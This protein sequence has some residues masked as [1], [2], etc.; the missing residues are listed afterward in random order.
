MATYATTQD[1]IDAFGLREMVQL[2]NLDDA[3]AIAI[4]LPRLIQN[5]EKAF[6]R[7]N[8]LIAN[9]PD[10]R[11][12][13]PFVLEPINAANFDPILNDFELDLVRYYL[14][15]VLPR[16]DVR[17]RY[18]D[19]IA[20]LTLIGKCQMVLRLDSNPLAV[21]TSNPPIGIRVGVINPPIFTQ[22]RLSGY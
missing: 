17:K 14:D 22:E 2:T 18:E 4:N 13:M 6:A 11:A 7:I 16:E 1:F 3:A 10:V 5:Q 9:C 20:Q 21:T 8:G 19:A 12:A 15:Q